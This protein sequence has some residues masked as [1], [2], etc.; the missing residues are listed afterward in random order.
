MHDVLLDKFSFL[1]TQI[2]THHFVFK[3]VPSLFSLF[4][5]IFELAITRL[6]ISFCIFSTFLCSFSNL[7]G[8]NRLLLFRLVC[9][10]LRCTLW[11]L[12]CFSCFSN[13]HSTISTLR[14]CTCIR[15]CC[16]AYYCLILISAFSSDSNRKTC[17][18]FL[19]LNLHLSV[20]FLKVIFL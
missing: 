19:W 8:P 4:L 17:I 20:P 14:S 2:Q 9:L 15:L 6:N 1:F 10:L 12:D 3:H 18:F 16:C 7:I 11:L 13:S 5:I